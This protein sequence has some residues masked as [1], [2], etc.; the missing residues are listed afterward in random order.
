MAHSYL[1]GAQK[2][3]KVVCLVVDH[4]HLYHMANLEMDKNHLNRIHKQLTIKVWMN[5]YLNS[6]FLCPLDVLG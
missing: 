6:P 3:V 4:S 5:T 2:M 1:K